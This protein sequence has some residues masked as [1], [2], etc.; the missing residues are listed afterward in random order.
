MR[1]AGRNGEVGSAEGNGE[2]VDAATAPGEKAPPV[3]EG[4]NGEAISRCSVARGAG[5]PAALGVGAVGADTGTGSGNAVAVG[6]DVG[7]ASG[8]TPVEG[9]VSGTVGNVPVVCGDSAEGEDA[10]SEDCWLAGGGT[11]L[12]RASRRPRT[13]PKRLG[14]CVGACW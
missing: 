6:G 9:E 14:F 7:A 11:K 10:K 2:K 1:E 5:V 4:C 12:L 8:N 3:D 13:V